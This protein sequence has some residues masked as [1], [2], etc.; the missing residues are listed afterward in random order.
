MYPPLCLLNE[1]AEFDEKSLDVLSAETKEKITEK[2]DI[3]VKFK[4]KEIIK[5][6]KRKENI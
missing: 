4:I 1:T 2:P 6:H 3:K 5:N